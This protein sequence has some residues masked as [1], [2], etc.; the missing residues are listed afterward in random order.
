MIPEMG[1]FYRVVPVKVDAVEESA[2]MLRIRAA[3]APEAR[4][5]VVT[6]QWRFQ[7]ASSNIMS[8]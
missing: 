7:P 2:N 6:R 1:A 5:K 4:A 3:G 8:L